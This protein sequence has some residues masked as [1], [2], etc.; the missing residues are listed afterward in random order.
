MA[1]ALPNTTANERWRALAIALSLAALWFTL[2]QYRGVVN[3][4]PT[5]VVQA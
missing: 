5:Y 2:H 1:P 3:D 4:G